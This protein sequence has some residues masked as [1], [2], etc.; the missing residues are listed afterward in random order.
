MRDKLYS[1]GKKNRANKP[2]AQKQQEQREKEIS[3]QL[4]HQCKFHAG[5]YSKR[6]ELSHKTVTAI[7]GRWD[8]QLKKQ[9]PPDTR[10]VEPN[11]PD[12]TYS[13]QENPK[14][15]L[16]QRGPGD[17]YRAIESAPGYPDEIIE[18]ISIS[19]DKAIALAREYFELD[20]KYHDDP[21]SDW[22]DRRDPKDPDKPMWKFYL[23]VEQCKN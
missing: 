3:K 12:Y 21:F 9:I 7:H 16:P 11:C 13:N 14:P 4:C 15:T 10:P 8:Y 18:F 20:T 19:E 17:R 22:D 23:K 6:C 1:D 2:L 5:S